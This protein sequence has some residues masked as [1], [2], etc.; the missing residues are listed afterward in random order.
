MPVDLPGLSKKSSSPLKK[1]TPVIPII[2]ADLEQEGPNVSSTKLCNANP[3]A[4]HYHV[5][6][7]M[8]T[9]RHRPPPSVATATGPKAQILLIHSRFLCK[10]L[11]F[12]LPHPFSFS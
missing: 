7:L 6:R 10:W 4:H 9:A 2:D 11:I 12:K 1:A 8:A 3:K 5:S